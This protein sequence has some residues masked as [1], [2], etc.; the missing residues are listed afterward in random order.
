MLYILCKLVV[1]VQFVLVDER[2][3]RVGLFEFFQKFES[4]GLENGSR[5]RVNFHFESVLQNLLQKIV[6]HLEVGQVQR[7]DV[8]DVVDVLLNHLVV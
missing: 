8:N 1:L 5:F 7:N 3:H 6:G 2:V 4:E